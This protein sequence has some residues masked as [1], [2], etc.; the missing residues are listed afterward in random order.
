MATDDER[1][2]AI[3]ITLRDIYDTQVQM[4]KALQTVAEA[5]PAHESRL[6]EMEHDKLNVTD[7]RREQSHT[8]L[9]QSDHETRI[10][11]IE[12]STSREGNLEPRVRILE[13]FKAKTEGARGLFTGIAYVAGGAGVGFI[14]NH[15][16]K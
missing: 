5:V 6:N 13:G 7:Y 15:V 4:A 2:P 16:V 11:M 12:A 14:L 9:V 3:R 10:R 1:T 8:E